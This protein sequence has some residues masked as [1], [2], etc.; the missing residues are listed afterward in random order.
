MQVISLPKTTIAKSGQEC[1]GKCRGPPHKDYWTCRKAVR[2]TGKES[3][4]A[5]WDYCSPDSMHTRWPS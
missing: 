4:D 5:G 3:D 2:W 1:L